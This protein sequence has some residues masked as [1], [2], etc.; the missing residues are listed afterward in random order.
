M[1]II[2]NVAV[3][4]HAISPYNLVQLLPCLSQLLSQFYMVDT[5]IVYQPSIVKPN[6]KVYVYAA[7][8]TIQRTAIYLDSLPI[9]NQASHSLLQD[10]LIE[11][12]NE[13]ISNG[14]I[15]T[16][17]K[18]YNESNNTSDIAKIKELGTFNLAIDCPNPTQFIGG[19]IACALLRESQPLLTKVLRQFTNYVQMNLH[20][21]PI[22]SGNYVI[23]SIWCCNKIDDD[24]FTQAW[25]SGGFNTW[26][27]AVQDWDNH[28]NKRLHSPDHLKALRQLVCIF[29]DSTIKIPIKWHH[30]WQFWKK[31]L[32]FYE[33]LN[34]YF[35]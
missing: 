10:R 25:L 33:V 1:E 12:S 11:L 20:Q 28:L 22:D 15:F 27:L 7:T 32:N 30:S 18:P 16:P 14:L 8:V 19:N 3:P 17:A 23:N 29:S 9:L 35:K 2:L 24:N 13:F 26:Q 21:L 6:Q 34:T 4:K 5:P 31:N